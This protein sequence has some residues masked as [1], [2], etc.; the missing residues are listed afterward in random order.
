MDQFANKSAFA[1]RKAG[2][3][4]SGRRG[5]GRRSLAH[6]SS[7]GEHL[8]DHETRLAGGRLA[9]RIDILDDDLGVLAQ[10]LVKDVVYLG[11]L[12]GRVVAAAAHDAHDGMAGAALDHL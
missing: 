1:S 11:L 8:V 10:V 9:D 6:G 4:G 3:I 5:R 2:W 7:A 12:S